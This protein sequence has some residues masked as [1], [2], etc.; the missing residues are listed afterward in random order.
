MLGGSDELFGSLPEVIRALGS[1]IISLSINYRYGVQMT[2]YQNGFRAIR[3]D[4][5]RSLGLTSNITTIEQEMAMTCLRH[6]YRIAECAAHEFRRKGGVSKIS[7]M[8]WA[9]IYVW[10]LLCGIMVPRVPARR[11]VAP[12]AERA[13]GWQPQKEAKRG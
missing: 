9:P 6:G 11:A 7:V 3:T 10:N 4:V 8:R 5:A 13:S 1:M 12:D 2:D